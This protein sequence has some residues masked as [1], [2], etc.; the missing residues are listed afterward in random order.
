MFGKAEKIKAIQSQIADLARAIRTIR[1]EMEK[2]QRR[3]HSK[4]PDEAMSRTIEI[5]SS[6][7]GAAESVLTAVRLFDVFV[8]KTLDPTMDTVRIDQSNSSTKEQP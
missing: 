4:H 6:Q 7:M 1:K 5:L 2:R 8:Y 3:T